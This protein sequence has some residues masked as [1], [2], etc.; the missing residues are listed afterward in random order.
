MLRGPRGSHKTTQWALIFLLSLCVC[1]FVP[2]WL[3]P[4]LPR[5]DF[6]F[7]FF[8][9]GRASWPCAWAASHGPR[10]GRTWVGWIGWWATQRWERRMSV[11]SETLVASRSKSKCFFFSDENDVINWVWCVF[12]WPQPLTDVKP[13]A[14]HRRE[15]GRPVAAMH[16]ETHPIPVLVLRLYV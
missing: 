2:Q 8:S 9:R 11:A 13:T 6:L 1:M 4:L 5:L 16:S 15:G 12:L 10:Q 3:Q 7:I 14:T